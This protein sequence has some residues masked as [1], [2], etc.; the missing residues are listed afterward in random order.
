MFMYLGIM[1]VIQWRSVGLKEEVQSTHHSVLSLSVY[2]LFFCFR[3]LMFRGRI[4]L[5][6][7]IAMSSLVPDI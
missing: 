4:L 5:F 1:K 6:L 3:P 7:V 2:I